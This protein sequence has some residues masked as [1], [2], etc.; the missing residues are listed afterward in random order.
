M[1][2]KK[3]KTQI[4]VQCGGIVVNQQR[5]GQQTGIYPLGFNSINHQTAYLWSSIFS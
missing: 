5:A 3:L 4:P 1:D 2:F